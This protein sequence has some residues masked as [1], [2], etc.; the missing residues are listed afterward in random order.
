VTRWVTVFK[1]IYY[2][3]LSDL[4]GRRCTRWDALV[5]LGGKEMH[6]GRRRRALFGLGGKEML[7]LGRPSPT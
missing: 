1:I 2:S 6:E 7:T 4:V 3:V 5:G